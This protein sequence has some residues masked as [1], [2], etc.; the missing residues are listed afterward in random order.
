MAQTPQILLMH[1]S[2]NAKLA[3]KVPQNTMIWDTHSSALPTFNVQLFCIFSPKPNFS[4]VAQ[5]YILQQH[6]QNHVPIIFFP[7][8]CSP[9]FELQVLQNV[10]PLR[11]EDDQTW[12]NQYESA[13]ILQPLH[14]IMQK[15]TD[16][17]WLQTSNAYRDGARAKGTASVLAVFDDGAPMICELG[18]VVCI[19]LC[20]HNSKWLHELIACTAQYLL[21]K[22]KA[23]WK[24]FPIVSS[25]QYTDVKIVIY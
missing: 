20:L 3:K 19:N 2:T 25:K 4:I 15:C 21:N 23:Q 7:F 13:Q 1:N 18:N 14:P 9:N 16:K 6:V 17:S 11:F 5:E 12:Q 22:K 8:P 24:W 10:H